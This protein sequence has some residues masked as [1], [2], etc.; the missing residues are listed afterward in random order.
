MNE[1]AF[2]GVRVPT[3]LKERLEA[4]AR[5][6]GTTLSE[7]LRAS[8]EHE[9]AKEPQSLKEA[10]EAVESNPANLNVTLDDEGALVAKEVGEPMAY[11]SPPEEVEVPI[12]RDTWIASTARILMMEKGLSK[13]AATMQATKEWEGLPND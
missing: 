7:T 3:E 1:K 12:G 9:W 5:E 10:R 6:K 4:E 13:V 8:L 11:E 2:I